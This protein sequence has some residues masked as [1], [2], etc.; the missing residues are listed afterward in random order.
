[1]TQTNPTGTVLPL[2]TSLG[3]QIRSTHRLF[4]RYLQGKIE[5]FGV[6]L[7]MWYFLRVLWEEDGLTQRELSQRVGTMEPTTL[8]AIRSMER[9]GFI[10]RERNTEDGRK[11]NIFLTQ[12]GRGLQAKLL[13][14][15]RE[16]VDDAASTL[17]SEDRQA[18][19]ALLAKVQAN[20]A[21]KMDR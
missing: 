17:T 19:L 10:R 8:T 21:A 15:A 7:G 9:S 11:I 14:L 12:D 5:P 3:Y 2:D 4:Q 1:V 20:L 6:S 18:M 13:P 16:V